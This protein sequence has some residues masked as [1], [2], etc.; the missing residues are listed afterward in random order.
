MEGS[1]VWMCMSLHR[2]IS[3]ALFFVWLLFCCCWFSFYPYP[4]LFALISFLIY[5]FPFLLPV[6]YLMRDSK[7]GHRFEWV[8][9]Q[10]REEK[11][12]GE[13][14]L[15]SESNVWKNVFSILKS[16]NFSPGW[17]LLI[18]IIFLQTISPKP[19]LNN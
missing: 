7:K 8:K 19:K 4:S 12:K 9:R 6:G 14:K 11:G 15:P 17:K 1:C 16:K 13:G 3:C 5:L 18:L 10:G 2:Y